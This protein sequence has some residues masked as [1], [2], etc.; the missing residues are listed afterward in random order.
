[1]TRKKLFMMLTFPKNKWIQSSQKAISSKLSKSGL[2]LA[3]MIQP[4]GR[5]SII[6][7]RKLIKTRCQLIKLSETHKL[8]VIVGRLKQCGFS[9]QISSRGWFK[10]VDIPKLFPFKSERFCKWNAFVYHKIL[11]SLFGGQKEFNFTI[12]LWNS[13]T[14]RLKQAIKSIKQNNIKRIAIWTVILTSRP[15]DRCWSLLSSSNRLLLFV[16]YHP[17][18]SISLPFHNSTPS[19]PT[20]TPLTFIYF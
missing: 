6:E 19:T 3:I 4:W 9:K 14:K 2:R 5:N 8:W 13:K 20:S 1:M 10:K 11:L 12:I 16:S 18:D 15:I 17:H 7:S